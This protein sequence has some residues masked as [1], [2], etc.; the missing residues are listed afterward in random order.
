MTSTRLHAL[1]FVLILAVAGVSAHRWRPTIHIADSMEKMNL[2]AVFPTQIGPWSVVLNVPAMIVSPDVAAMLENLYAQTL[3]RVY[4]ND[5]GDRIML[6][7]AY[8]GDQSDATRAHRPDVCYPAQGFQLLSL[9]SGSIDLPNGPLPVRRMV[10]KQGSRVEP[11]TFWF[12]VGDSVA[13]TG[14][15]QKL[16]Q[17]RYGTRGLI[18]DGMLIRVSSI[19]TAEQEAFAIQENFIRELSLSMGQSWL[20]RVFGKN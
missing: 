20:P 6:S 19:S 2:E 11:V 4:V 18:P 10:A 8:G 5:K 14:S 9:T 17:L 12:A 7:V 16:I 15:Q 13:I 3:S 1:L